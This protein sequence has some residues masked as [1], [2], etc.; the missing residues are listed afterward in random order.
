MRSLALVP[1]LLLV[2]LLL[3]ESVRAYCRLTTEMPIAGETC[4]ATGVPLFW[5]TQCLG[6]SVV[7]RATGKPS[8]AELRAVI[9]D[10][11]GAW[12]EVA[13]DTTPIGLDLRQ[14]ADVATCLDPEYNQD[15]PNANTVI[16]LDDWAERGLPRVAFGLTLV[17]HHPQT[18]EIFDADLQINETL[19]SLTICDGACPPRGV[20]IQNVVTHEAGHYLGL[21]HSD[22]TQA[23]MSARA[24]LGE[25]LKRTLEDDDRVGVCTIYGDNP[26]VACEPLDFDPDNGFG[27][28]CYFAEFDGGCG[29]GVPGRPLSVPSAPLGALAALVLLILTRSRRRVVASSSTPR[30]T[31]R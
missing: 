9:D 16:F 5:S 6:Y 7:P 17:W 30:P 2:G 1:P 26:P 21:G 4:S 15:G 13:C 24:T 10:S 12:T 18:G 19:G 27:P 31:K 11:F 20:D 8:L 3:P 22:V 14:T 25:T 29:C 23:T 28:A